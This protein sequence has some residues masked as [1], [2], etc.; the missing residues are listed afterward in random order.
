VTLDKVNNRLLIGHHGN[1]RYDI[2]NIDD[3]GLPVEGH[4]VY[5][6][7]SELTGK[8]FSTPEL[9]DTDLSWPG[10][11]DIDEVNQ[12]LFVPER[13]MTG[14]AGGRIMVFNIDP[15]YL[16]TLE[17]GELP[18]ALAVIGQPNFNTIDSR[19]GQAGI[20][21]TGQAIV[22][23][24]RQL[25]FFSDSRNNRVMIWNID[26]DS[27][28]TGMD[29][30]AVIGQ[31][32]FN[33]T[34]RQSGPEGL[35]GAGSLAYDP[36]KQTLFVS[37][38][39][40]R[41]MVF[42]VSAQALDTNQH[43][44]AFAVL[45]QLDYDVNAPRPSLRKFPGGGPISV[46]YRYNRLFVGSFTENRVL[47]FDV[48]PDKLNGPS[49]PDAIA[50]LGQPDYESM[51]PAV[52]QTRLTMTRIT[53]D[54][55]RQLAYVPDGYPAGNHINIFDIHPDRMLEFL[56]PQIDQI[57]HINPE[58]D[59]DFE[60]RAA[61]DR[62]SGKFWTQG[63]DVTVDTVD[64]RLFL[65]DFY[66]HRVL[67]FQLDRMNRLLD[68]EATWAIG[69]EDTN[70]EVLLPGR[71]SSA[72]KLPMAVEY[73]SS[74]KR[75]FVADT[76]N[77]RVLAFD[78]TPGQV[79]SGMAAT[80]VLGQETFESYEVATAADRISFGTRNARGIGPSGGR[81]AAM[82]LDKVNQRLFVSDGENNRVLVFDM[83]PDRITSGADAIGVLG[84]SNFTS[85]ESG[86]NAGKFSL[87]G[88]MVMD[89]ANQR[90][91]VELPF[92][93]RILVFDVAPGTF[94]N[95][96]A[97]SWVIGQPDFTTS[98][99]GMSRS[100]IRQPDG[101][102]YDPVQDHLYVT[103]KFNNR[104]LTFDVH[105]DRMTNMPEAI[106]VIGEEDYVTASVGP[107]IYRD[108]HDVLFDP[109]GNFFDPVGRRLFQSEGT[110]GRLTVFTLPRETYDLDFP[111]RSRLRYA[112]TDAY[113]L[114]GGEPLT[115]GYAVST[116]S[117]AASLASVNTHYITR[118][119]RQQGSRRQSRELESVAMLAAGDAVSTATFYVEASDDYDVLLSFVN[120][121][122]VPASI[123]FSLLT[124]DGEVDT[125]SRTILSTNQLSLK[126]SELFNSPNIQGTLQISSSQPVY[127]QG[128]LEVDD[129]QGQTI[130]AP[131]PAILG[132]QD[133]SERMG[134]RR[135]L[136][137]IPTGAGSYAR[138]VLLNTSEDVIRG[139][140]EVTDQETVPYEI[141][142]GQAYVH[143]IPPDARPLLDGHAIVSAESGDAPEAFALVARLNRDNSMSSLH[144]V[145]S[146]QEGPLFWAPLDTYPDVLH[147]GNIDSTLHVVNALQIPA[148]IYLEWFDMDGNSVETFDRT[149]VR[150]ESAVL[151]LEEVFG[152]SPLRGTLRVF[153]DTGVSAT[154]LESTRTVLGETVIMDVPLQI[155]PQEGKS[156]FVF[157]LFRNGDGFAT[158]MLTINTDRAP[159]SGSIRMLNS[160]GEAMEVILR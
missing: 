58:G 75:L 34:E 134:E 64:H 11:G 13:A 73:D 93:D 43:K 63:R 126:V 66:G 74:N 112:S 12:R 41:V 19:A 109:R 25:L 111:A 50:V 20:G 26:P 89:E 129:G 85:N 142:P 29:A 141:E 15:E 121:N 72:L 40:K 21:S 108:H 81:P 139:T 45:G 48:A 82:A 103:D 33:S 147:N 113:K 32:D 51:D 17:P 136:P 116:T 7:G 28:E 120:D 53:V 131:A 102:S 57:G 1:S 38:G 10:G 130:I 46:D 86:L 49:D 6:I 106:G 14:G 99:P 18:P 105:P 153:S 60:A 27:L 84:Q 149:I 133:H 118:E 145:T 47:I 150:G 16:D 24:E 42:D 55:E 69:Q 36:E 104:I 65:N 67:V 148:T 119:Y 3:Q 61:H 31:P 90:L 80:H 79:E 122:F 87:P 95:G 158:E 23:D 88:D 4:A 5:S 70:T 151:N 159:H 78:M 155:T 98:I 152:Q 35:A 9:N 94:K 92:Q 157:P 125:S 117:Q 115:E 59:P 100:G 128:L 154:L 123:E 8:G 107:G 114:S 22:D 137:A 110:N 101:I 52:T 146:H 77:N 91:F 144:T 39:K 2:Y 76:W 127:I 138:I 71:T 124:L 132:E 83:H 96:M 143:N 140:L 62:V 97:A 56:T 30:I 156:R 37:D 160:D 54:T 44:T 135:I 68:R